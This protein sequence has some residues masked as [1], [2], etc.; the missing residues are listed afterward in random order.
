MLKK[1]LMWKA[2]AQISK[3]KMINLTILRFKTVKHQKKI[4]KYFQ[5]IKSKKNFYSDNITSY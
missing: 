2:K 4:Q 5:Y 1:F 3:K